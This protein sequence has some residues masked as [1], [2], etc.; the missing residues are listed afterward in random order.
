MNVV[1]QF[2]DNIIAL[3]FSEMIPSRYKPPF[4]D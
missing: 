3:F 4:L 2:L 1:G